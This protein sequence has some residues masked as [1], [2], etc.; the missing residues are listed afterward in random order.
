M[1]L[2]FFIIAAAVICVVVYFIV[3]QPEVHQDVRKLGHD[4]ER[5]VQ[6]SY[7]TTRDAVKDSVK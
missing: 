2:F 5:G 6:D 1:K 3:R 7:D 4:V